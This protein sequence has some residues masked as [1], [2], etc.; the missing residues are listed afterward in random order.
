MTRLWLIRH[1]EPVE[2]ARHR[3][4]GSL[5]VELSGTGR[6]Q[7]AQVA[8]YLRTEPVAAIYSSPSSRALE[9][10]RILSA[11]LSC[12]VEI[13]PDLRE[14][15]F[16]DFEGLTWDEI[17]A[18]YPNAYRQWMETPTEMQFPNGESF[19]K[20]RARVLSAFD[21]IRREQEDRT[22]VIVS[23]GGV[24]RILIAW[25]LQMPDN[26]LFRLAQDYAAINLLVFTD[27]VPAIQ[28]V[29]YCC[30]RY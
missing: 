24:N 20:M 12:P 11:S 18:R 8:E 5:D 30:A 10:A 22:V 3:C 4:Y 28:L 9:S 7:M 29:N 15:D 13:A 21:T 25:T 6:A 2:Q 14:I 27:G 19:P 23:H 26:C 17:S 16:G 1:G